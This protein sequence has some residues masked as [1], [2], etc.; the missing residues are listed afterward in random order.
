MERTSIGG[1]VRLVS[2]S[3]FGMQDRRWCEI[4]PTIMFFL[5]GWSTLSNC[6]VLGGGVVILQQKKQEGRNLHRC[7]RY[8]LVPVT[9]PH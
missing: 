9:L 5:V 6:M 3:S 2:F 4:D 1:C 7:C 8:F